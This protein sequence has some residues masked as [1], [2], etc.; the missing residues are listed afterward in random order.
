MLSSTIQHFE[1]LLNEVPQKLSAFTDAAA[2]EK[3]RP[4]KWSKKE[5]MGH[6]ID[7]AANNHQRFVRLQIQDNIPL[8]QYNQNEWVKLQHYNERPWNEIIQLWHSYNI[9][10][11]HVMRHI[12]NN[13]LGH[14]GIFPDYGEQT[15]SYILEDYVVH[16]EHHLKQTGIEL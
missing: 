10:L 11:L 13:A 5:I 12:K 9:H 3:I 6:L 15:L 2:T 7:S 1:K 16:L 8:L 4:G 14:T